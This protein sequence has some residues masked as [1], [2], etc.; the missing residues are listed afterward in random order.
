MPAERQPSLP[1]T[2]MV[3]IGALAALLIITML[4]AAS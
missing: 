3:G 2:V 1:I 4:L